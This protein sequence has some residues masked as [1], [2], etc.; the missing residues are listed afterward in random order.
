MTCAGGLCISPASYIDK[1][2]IE[3]PTNPQSQVAFKDNGDNIQLNGMVI[4]A[5][6]TGNNNGFTQNGLQI[7]YYEPLD[8]I[9]LNIYGSP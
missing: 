9:S 3:S 2:T 1:N 6:V 7:W 4:E 5:S 8:V